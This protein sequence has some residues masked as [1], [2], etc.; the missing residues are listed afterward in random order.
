[1][2]ARC[3]YLLAIVASASLAGCALLS[4]GKP[5]Q[6]YRLSGAAE[7][8]DAAPPPSAASRTIL[9]MPVRIDPAIN[10]DRMLAS[11]GSET[12]YIAR[13]RWVT[14]LGDQVEQM[15]RVAV[16]RRSP[17]IA[18]LDRRDGLSAPQAIQ[19]TVRRFEA[20]F[21]QVDSAPEVIVEGDVQLIDLRTRASVARLEV[22]TRSQAT[23][24][25]IAAIMTA[26][27]AAAVDAVGRTADWIAR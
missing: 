24:S 11:R 13:A 21:A 7:A 27:D 18:L 6:L 10:G 14:P 9:L 8:P 19:L 5:A 15:L 26:F 12:S 16:R 1:M 22:S 4:G 3:S 25:D 17:S 23:S 20:R 2:T